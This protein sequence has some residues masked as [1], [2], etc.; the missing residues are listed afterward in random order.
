MNSY[1]KLLERAH[2][3]L[4]E[5]SQKSDRFEIPSVKGHIQGNKTII[6]C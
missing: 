3:K 6:S 2:S 5:K 1:E 4:P